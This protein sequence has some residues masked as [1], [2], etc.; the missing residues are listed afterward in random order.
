MI[1]TGDIYSL[2]IMLLLFVHQKLFVE[3]DIVFENFQ[4]LVEKRL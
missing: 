4:D 3:I 2:K 1:L